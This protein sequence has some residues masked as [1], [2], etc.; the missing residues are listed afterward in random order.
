MNK[1]DASKPATQK[2]H[3]KA[4]LK[5]ARSH[6]GRSDNGDAFIPDPGSGPARTSDD[7]AEQVAESFLQSATS[8]E[9]AGEEIANAEVPEEMGG[10]FVTTTGKQEFASGTDA[11]NPADAEVAGFPTAN[12]SPS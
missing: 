9:E 3:S 7:L 2:Q 10:P 11:S 8:G 1:R 5:D 12:S 6:A 4:F